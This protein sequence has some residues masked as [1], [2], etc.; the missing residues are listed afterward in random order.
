MSAWSITV[1]GV[2]QDGGLPHP[3]C[4]C[5]RCDGARRGTRRR[6]KV[7]CLGLTDGR[8]TWLVDATPDL[9]EQLHALTSSLPHAASGPHAAG[10]VGASGAARSPDGVFLT[11]AHMG[12]YVGLAYLGKEAL[13]ARGMVLHG[14]R[15]MGDFLHDNAPWCAL[16][17]EGRATFDASGAV[18]LGGG[19]R[20]ETIPV[21]H[22]QE[23]TDAVAWVLRGPRKSALWLPDIDSWDAWDRNVRDVVAS[24]DVAFLDATFF[25]DGELG[26]RDMSEIPHP[27]V[28]ETMDRLAGLESRVRL[29]HLNH[30]NPLWDDDSPATSRGFRVAREGE[31][32]EL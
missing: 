18:D 15:R 14:T 26:T 24:V 4:V 1:L 13:G 22:R 20:A 21:P 3:G 23:F 17:D 28:V 25:A 2:A 11:H 27:R 9:P 32:F 29:V 16:L 10:A 5:A 12:H 19:L 7:A 30:T 6:E 8:R 31:T